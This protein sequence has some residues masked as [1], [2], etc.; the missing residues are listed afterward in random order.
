MA[1][2]HE[3]LSPE[4]ALVDPELAARARRALPDRSLFDEPVPVEIAAGAAAR[5]RQLPR[6]LVRS[7][8]LVV[9]AASLAL[10][11]GLLTDR[12][13]ASG[14]KA[15]TPNV[16]SGVDAAVAVKRARPRR[17]QPRL[18]LAESPPVSRAVLR[19]PR[20]PAAVKYDVVIWRGHRRVLDVWTSRS[21]FELSDLSCLQARKLVAGRRYLWFVYPVLAR[22]STRR[23]GPLLDWGALR[24][25]QEA[26][27]RCR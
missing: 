19:W 15:A 5:R 16:V 10:N 9:L 11:V 22:S 20:T 23:F 1:G 27:A 4:L 25:R 12:R 14:G 13:P 18:R 17:P 21:R 2:V 8:T 26:G 6:T 3:P 24:P 7:G